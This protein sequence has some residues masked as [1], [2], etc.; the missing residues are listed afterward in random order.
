MLLQVLWQ[1]LDG[2]PVH[3]STLNR[4]NAC[5]SRTAKQKAQGTGRSAPHQED[6]GLRDDHP[7][8][9]NPPSHCDS[10]RGWTNSSWI[11]GNNRKLLLSRLS[12]WHKRRLPA[13]CGATLPRYSD[14]ADT[15]VS[16]NVPRRVTN[17]NLDIRP[18]DALLHVWPDEK[19]GF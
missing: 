11:V 2:H 17:S 18:D 15:R 3:T 19:G 14:A 12:T 16:G 6:A 5:L 9:H 1:L 4:F 10:Q 13:K 7:S 8:R